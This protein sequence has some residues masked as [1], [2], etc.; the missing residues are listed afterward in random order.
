MASKKTNEINDMTEQLK[1]SKSNS[2]SSVSATDKVLSGSY[3]VESKVPKTKCN[4][5]CDPGSSN[6]TSSPDPDSNLQNVQFSSSPSTSSD[7]ESQIDSSSAN[8]DALKSLYSNKV[9]VD[10]AA[11][12]YD[13]VE[14]F[15]NSL[16]NVPKKPSKPKA[17]QPPPPQV[18]QRQFLPEQMAV[19][20]RKKSH[21]NVIKYMEKQT[22]GPLS[23]LAKCVNDGKRIRVFTRNAHKQ[24][25]ECVGYI[26]AFDKHW[27]MALVD[28]DETF[29]RKRFRKLTAT[30][31]EKDCKT[32]ENKSGSRMEQVGT[33]LIKVIKTNRNSELCQR[34]MTQ[35]VLRGE[36]VVSVSLVKC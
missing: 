26:V 21:P 29:T 36:H 22:E 11:P 19:E 5:S 33:S 4:V 31:S 20:S 16:K 25:G 7:D 3:E 9:K 24:R 14:K 27:N 17:E 12:I 2:S 13:N 28:V 6:P 34:H 18:L 23:V 30:G 8:F 35:I 15:V 32:K 1:I 10:P